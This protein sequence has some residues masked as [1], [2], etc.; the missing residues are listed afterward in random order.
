[1]MTFIIL[2][3]KESGVENIGLF[4][5]TTAAMLMLIRPL[6]GKLYDRKGHPWVIIPGTISLGI[7]L[8][9]LSYS[10]SIFILTLASIFYGVGYGMISP[11]LHAWTVNLAPAHRRGS[12]NGTFYSAIDLGIGSGAIILGAVANLT[13]YAIMYRLSVF[14][15]LIFLVIYMSHLRNERIR[16]QILEHQYVDRSL[17]NEFQS[18][19]I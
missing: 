15:V 16:N 4:F 13:G 17:L 9:I 1:V 11:V 10:A 7:G 3:G 14:V 12:A 5:I 6:S 18:K 2:F 8:I 19:P